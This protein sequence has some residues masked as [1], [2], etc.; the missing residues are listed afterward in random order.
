MIVLIFLREKP[1]ERFAIALVGIG[2]VGKPIDVGQPVIA[3]GANGT[4]L[5]AQPTGHVAGFELLE[6]VSFRTGVQQNEVW[7]RAIELSQL[8]REHRTE[9]R[10]D[11][12][13]ARLS[14]A[15]QKID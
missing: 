11:K 5:R 1:S 13:L 15:V 12:W 8:L 2:H 9:H 10:S 3:T 4:I 14:T 6:F 7:N